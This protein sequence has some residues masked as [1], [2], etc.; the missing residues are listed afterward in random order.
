MCIWF[1]PKMTR[2]ES[3][4]RAC[5][6]TWRVEARVRPLR[7]PGRAAETAAAAAAAAVAATRI[8]LSNPRSQTRLLELW[9]P[10]PHSPT[11]GF[12]LS[13]LCPLLGRR[14]V[15]A[16]RRIM[17]L[18]GLEE[19]GLGVGGGARAPAG[20]RP[21]GGTYL[22]LRP[23]LDV[24]KCDEYSYRRRTFLAAGFHNND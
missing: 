7:H 12:A 15:F 13:I 4:R 17:G 14:R 10:H 2:A 18:S 24:P 23:L 8:I 5:L 16:G 20:G 9:R 11:R 21:F 3:T 6:F 19:L 22:I 1:V